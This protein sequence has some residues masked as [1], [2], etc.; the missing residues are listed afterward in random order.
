[1]LIDEENTNQLVSLAQKENLQKQEQFLLYLKE[2]INHVLTIEVLLNNSVIVKNVLYLYFLVENTSK[3]LIN[4]TLNFNQLFK[5]NYNEKYT[6]CDSIKHIKSNN[7]VQF[8][9]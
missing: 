7:K 5:M 3:D 2:G 4:N 9:K 8:R 6:K 1:M